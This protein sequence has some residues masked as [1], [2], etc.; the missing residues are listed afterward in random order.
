MPPPTFVAA[1]PS[2]S[3]HSSDET[4][5][6]DTPHTNYTAFSSETVYKNNVLNG[7]LPKFKL[8]AAIPGCSN[9]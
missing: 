7:A 8:N 6:N 2:S 9:N 5:H 3:P 4:T 1:V